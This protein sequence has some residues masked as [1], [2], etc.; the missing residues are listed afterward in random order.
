MPE[1]AS[2]NI[3]KNY[4]ALTLGKQG[5]GLYTFYWLLPTKIPIRPREI[6]Y[7]HSIVLG[8]L[9]VISYTTRLTPLISLTILDDILPRSS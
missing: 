1:D 4:I 6:S 8:G 3:Y 5:K 9:V 7:S 2:C